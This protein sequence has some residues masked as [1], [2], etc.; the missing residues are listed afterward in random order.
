MPYK[1][2]TELRK[3]GNL[4]GAY[5]LAIQCLLDEPT[6]IWVRH[7]MSWVLL[8]KMKSASNIVPLLE[9][10]A[11]LDLDCRQESMFYDALT[12]R[13]A[14][15]V[16]SLDLRSP[17]V[18]VIFNIIKD[19]SFKP[20]QGYSFLFKAFHAHRGS[21]LRYIEFCEWWGFYNF[22]PEDY[23]KY[24]ISSGQEVMSLVEQAYIGYAKVL[25]GATNA[26]ERIYAFLPQ[27]EKI[28]SEHNEYQYPPYFLAKL[29][30]KI[31]NR[32]AA[33]EVLLPFLRRKSTDYWVWQTVGDVATD[34]NVKFSCYSKALLCR[35][36]PEMLVAIKEAYAIML[37]DRK[38]YNEAKTEIEQIIAIRNNNGWRLT[39]NINNLICLEWYD[40]ATQ[41]KSN[42]KCYETHQQ[43]AI[44]LF[45]SD[46]TRLSVL[47]VAINKQKKIV[48]YVTSDRQNGAFNY[49]RVMKTP[50]TVG[51]K[52][53][54]F[55]AQFGTDGFGKATL[56]RPCATPDV[57]AG[58]VIEFAGTLCVDHARGF[59]IVRFLGK[60][61]F[62]PRQLVEGSV[63]GDFVEGEAVASFDKKQQ[64]NG[65]T[66][67]KIH[68]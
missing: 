49:M 58:K 1:R 31:D 41:L 35:A 32:S 22:L 40:L 51:D 4:D 44:D 23:C 47:V 61:I 30:L 14:Q 6:N 48:N 37:A 12:W 64:K 2:I 60:Q 29:Y 24:K 8:D 52:L 38:L 5:S 36:K 17:Q 56:V 55:F 21:W 33:M 20:S 11:D 28:Y 62:V 65:W 45:A 63:N 16:K 25:I 39:E 7:A 68:K 46:L 57:W 42:V 50:P 27:L 67:F 13:I 34:D 54:V 3:N 18:D 53:D 59:G 26:E 9:Q 15:Y 19:F 66:A 43:A 10:V